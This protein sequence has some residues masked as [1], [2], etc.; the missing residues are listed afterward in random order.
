VRPAVSRRIGA[1]LAA[2]WTAAG[3]LSRPQ[4]VTRSFSID[5]PTPRTESPSRGVV[6]QLA[7]VEVSP[8]YSG[9]RLVYQTGE[10]EFERD[11]YARFAAPPGWLLTIAIRGYLAN[12]DFVRDVWAAGRGARPDVFVDVAVTQLAGEFRDGAFSAKIVL[13]VRA[14]PQ[15]PDGRRGSEI[16]LKTYSRAVSIPHANAADV[17]EGW[18]RGLAEIMAELE[19][20]LR[21][22][23]SASGVTA[24]SDAPPASGPGR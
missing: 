4:L 22:T 10:H 16:L 5:P 18:N 1:L 9:Q 15:R 21:A 6:V 17:V 24:G 19:A 8:P 12:A 11:P 7:R 2:S 3:C 20:D 13:R 14:I 23:L